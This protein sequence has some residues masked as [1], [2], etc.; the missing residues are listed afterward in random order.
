MDCFDDGVSRVL[1]DW[2][3]SKRRGPCQWDSSIS[4]GDTNSD[5][6]WVYSWLFYTLFKGD[7]RQLYDSQHAT[8]HVSSFHYEGSTKAEGHSHRFLH[9]QVPRPARCYSCSKSGNM[10]SRVSSFPLGSPLF[11]SAAVF[12]L[13]H[14]VL[15]PTIPHSMTLS[16][17][18]FLGC[19]TCCY[20]KQIFLPPVC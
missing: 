6:V 10:L 11:H 1:E 2:R 13:S 15:K 9:P 5:I 14:F 12:E 20:H 16:G 4:L 7:F 19:R 17:L 8:I 3:T 18:C